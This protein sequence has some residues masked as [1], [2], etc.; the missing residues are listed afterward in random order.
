[1]RQNKMISSFIIFHFLLNSIE[2]S[3]FCNENDEIHFE[4]WCYKLYDINLFVDF[5]QC[6]TLNNTQLN[7]C[8]KYQLDK[9]LD[10]YLLNSKIDELHEFTVLDSPF[11]GGLSSNIFLQLIEKKNLKENNDFDFI[12]IFIHVY[13]YQNHGYIENKPTKIQSPNLLKHSDSNLS[14][15]SE[16]CLFVQQTKNLNE[17]FSFKYGDCDKNFTFI[18]IKSPREV[19]HISDRCSSYFES[20]PGGKWIEC[21]QLFQIIDEN[22][23]HFISNSQKCCMYN[24]NWK[25]NFSSAKKICSQFDSEV[26]SFES[27]GF[28]SILNSY[29][30][31]LDLNPID[32]SLSEYTNFWTSCKIINYP[33]NHE[34]IC[35]NALKKREKFDFEYPLD[36]GFLLYYF[37]YSLKNQSAFKILKLNVSQV[38]KNFNS[39]DSNQF[40][41]NISQNVFLLVRRKETH[42][43]NLNTKLVDMQNKSCYNYH[44]NEEEKLVSFPILDKCIHFDTEVMIEKN[45]SENFTSDK[46]MRVVN[47]FDFKSMICQMNALSYNSTRSSNLEHI[48][49]NYLEKNES[50]SLI[51]M[52]DKWLSKYMNITG[53]IFVFKYITV[54]EKVLYLNCYDSAKKIQNLIDDCKK[55][56]FNSYCKF[57]C[58]LNCDFNSDKY[59][60]IIWQIGQFKYNFLSSICKSAYH[61][62]KTEG[63]IYFSNKKTSNK[64][65]SLINNGIDSLNWPVFNNKN[66]HQSD[67]FY[68]P[69]PAAEKQQESW[70]NFTN[71]L[72]LLKAIFFVK[73]NKF[74]SIYLNILSNERIDQIK[75]KYMIPMFDDFY[76]VDFRQ[77]NNYSNNFYQTQLSVNL[78]YRKLIHINNYFEIHNNGLKFPINLANID[79]EYFLLN[80]PP[81]IRILSN[82]TSK[83]KF[84]QVRNLTRPLNCFWYLYNLNTLNSCTHEFSFST[85]NSTLGTNLIFFPK[86]EDMDLNFFKKFTR[87]IFVG[88]NLDKCL[89]GGYFKNGKCICYPG[90]GGDQCEK[91]C[92]IGK[93]GHNCEYECPN[94]DCKGYL[95]CNFDPIGCSCISGL[96]GFYCDQVCPEHKWGP[97]CSFECKNCIDNKCNPFNGNC[98]CNKNFV[99]NCDDCIDGFYGENCTKKCTNS[100]IKCN[101]LNGKCLDDYITK[102][103]LNST[104]SLEEKTDDYFGFKTIKCQDNFFNIFTKQLMNKSEKTISCFLD[105][106]SKFQYCNFINREF[107][108]CALITDNN[109]GFN[110]DRK[111]DLITEVDNIFFKLE[112]L[113]WDKATFIL[114]KEL[115]FF[116]IKKIIL[117]LVNSSNENSLLFDILEKKY[118]SIFIFCYN[119]DVI[120]LDF[121]L[122]FYNSCSN[123]KIFHNK[124]LSNGYYYLYTIIELYNEQ[125]SLKTWIKRKKF[126]FYLGSEQIEN[127]PLNDLTNET[128]NLNKCEASYSENVYLSKCKLVNTVLYSIII[129]S[130]IFFVIVFENLKQLSIRKYHMY[131][132]ENILQFELND[133]FNSSF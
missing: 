24:F 96:K 17:K 47:F 39:I 9:F 126:M 114:Q 63:L 109:F 86:T 99:E 1:M 53:N 82:L 80:N 44:S 116:L 78:P 36:N 111:I 57:T 52:N 62:N 50:A 133:K 127:C 13:S 93:F 120:N 87:I 90:F 91:I 45:N 68:F 28:K 46:I 19:K 94:S 125:I 67:Y 97:M 115:N 85:N 21:D 106:K 117:V 15:S 130:F 66:F 33:I 7:Q 108:Q 55:F 71:T 70:K 89:Y 122:Y 113:H 48:C 37:H 64:I 10:I 83:M 69:N 88:K 76:N 30:L 118:V 54:I 59:Q 31:Y 4:T 124:N 42:A 35:G 104:K 74:N 49:S 23:T 132:D 29:D 14:N 131:L 22:S 60:I 100:C 129:L 75:L 92:Q 103:V 3:L 26:F 101:R 81:L 58:P 107:D 105:E 73:K 51:L 65:T 98:V 27:K 79:Y 123:Y 38:F 61:S 84:Q 6:W 25:V 43:T 32:S 40:I 8:F 128:Y 121:K 12:N 5:K 34:F 41:K 72:V 95:I 110:S 112:S 2:A 77:E 16:K 119:N 56:Y 102:N 20:S 18:C 11:K